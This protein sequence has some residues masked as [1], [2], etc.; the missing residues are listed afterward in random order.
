[1]DVLA[2]LEKRGY[3]TVS[4]DFYE[5]IRTSMEWDKGKVDSFH[6]YNIYNGASFVGCERY[7]LGMPK[8]VCEDWANLLMNERV[9]I[10]ADGYTTLHDT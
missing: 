2:W 3:S 5:Q 8:L 9:V 4:A 1:M 6:K 7:S 10:E